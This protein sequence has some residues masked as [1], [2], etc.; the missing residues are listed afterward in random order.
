MVPGVLRPSRPPL[1]P[2]EKRR[3]EVRRA[4]CMAGVDIDLDAHAGSQWRGALVARINAHAPGKSLQELYPVA[5]G[6]LRWEGRTPLGRVCA[7][8]L[9][10]ARRSQAPAWF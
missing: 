5:A 6:F 4:S 7:V 10:R 8:A 3:Q 1:L 2:A 9:Y